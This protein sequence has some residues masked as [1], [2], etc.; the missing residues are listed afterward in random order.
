MYLGDDS[1]LKIVGHGR[2]KIRFP[3]GRVKGIDGF[4]HILGLEQNLLYVSKLNDSRAQVFF[5]S[6]ECKMTRGVMVLAK[7]VQISTLFKLDACTIQ[8][9]I[10]YDKPK[11]K[12]LDSSSSLSDRAEKLVV[13]TSNG[14]AFWVPKGEL[15]H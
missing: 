8:C 5:S 15:I 9:N 12:S 2:V 10:C 4:L 6:G 11:K 3:N 14:H 7:G 1:H 13:A